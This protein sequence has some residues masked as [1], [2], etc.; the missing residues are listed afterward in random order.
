MFD[1]QYLIVSY[2]STHS[3]NSERYLNL[4]EINTST[5]A[6]NNNELTEFSQANVYAKLFHHSRF[7]RHRTVCVFLSQNVEQIT[8]DLFRLLN[9]FLQ[10]FSNY[11]DIANI[12]VQI[13]LKTYCLPVCERTLISLTHEGTSAI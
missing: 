10:R 4:I 6:I 3:C 7:T 5:T 2:S 9:E 1:S 12:Y 13:V 11:I 8:T